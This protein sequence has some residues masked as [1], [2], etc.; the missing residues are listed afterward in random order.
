PRTGPGSSAPAGR[1]RRGRARALFPDGGDPLARSFL[2]LCGALAVAP[3]LTLALHAIPGPLP[4]WLLIIAADL[5]SA[6]LI[7]LLAREQRSWERPQPPPNFPLLIII[8]IGV[9]LRLT[10]LGGAEFQGDEARA[11]L[12]AAGVAQG[13]DGILL[14]HT[15]GPVEA[16]L[17]AGPLILA[18][19]G[20]EWV[21]RLPFALA[22]VG[23]LLAAVAIARAMWPDAA[24]RNTVIAAVA[25]ALLATDGFALGFAR[26]VQYQSVV[27]LMSAG[28]FWCCWRFYAGAGRPARYLVS[29]AALLA[30]G[31]LAHYDAAMVAPALA[32]LVIAGG[33]RRGWRWREWLLGLGAP[34][35]VGGALLAS[36]YVPYVTGASFGATAAYLAGRAGQGKAGGPP[37]NNLPLYLDIMSFYNAPPLV[38]ILAIAM[39]VGLCLLPLARGAALPLAI[40]F[41]VPFAAE[42]FLIAEPRTH[43]Y[44]A[45][46]AAAL[47]I[48]YAIA[49]IGSVKS[50]SPALHFFLRV[51]AGAAAIL[52]LAA[53]LGYAQLLYL[54]QFPEYQRTFPAARPA[55]L[56][57]GYGDQLP[58]AGYFGFPHN[59]GWKAAAELYRTG[60]IA[61]SYDTNQNRWLAGWYLRG[62]PRC[63]DTPD[64]YLIAEAEA[65][66][67]FPPGYSLLGEV[68]VGP[69]RALAIYSRA[70]VSGPPQI[71]SGERLA[72]AFDARPVEPFPAAGTLADTPR[73]ECDG[74]Q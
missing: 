16:L 29:A 57:A 58:K 31:L 2:G 53:S 67:Y 69:A 7:W 62:A 56:R 74:Q 5:P 3:L 63:A 14:T 50:R 23:L 55:A 40:W 25:V 71:F 10:L 17:P 32:W 34:A 70:A 43:F 37:F 4:A 9:A 54:R 1:P 59:D 44:S 49:K 27:L 22:G 45:H 65:T 13:D 6:A 26:I 42:A 24:R 11:M 20:A 30:V 33:W 36:F 39:L 28:A 19:A 8:V 38:P 51:I 35:L 47:I 61:G 66:R 15:K 41:A 72:A 64:Y 73:A 12:L 68:T 18:G 60:V 48:G 52:W 21:A 46:P